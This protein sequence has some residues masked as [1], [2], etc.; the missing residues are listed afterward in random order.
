M[1]EMNKA[2]GLFM[3]LAK[4]EAVLRRRL[5]AGLGGLSFQEFIILYHLSQAPEEHMRR[6]D[7]ADK[8][9]LTPSGVTRLLLPMEKIGLVKRVTNKGDARV[10]LVR[11]AKGGR[12]H[13]S[14][15]LTR[16]AEFA[17]EL[18]TKDEQTKLASI[19]KTLAELEK[20]IR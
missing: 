3:E 17:E 20:K 7:L 13:L 6:I 19:G 14:E 15:A 18:L 1:K 2:V 16:S 10:S 8:V 11:L 9:G 12:E 4:V 5:D